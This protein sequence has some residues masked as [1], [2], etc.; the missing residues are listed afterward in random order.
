MT[1]LMKVFL[2]SWSPMRQTARRVGH[3]FLNSFIQLAS[4]DLGT[5]TMCGPL[6]FLN[7]ENIWNV[8]SI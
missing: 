5:S 3:H 2:V 7:K 8:E 6:M 1:S 4:V